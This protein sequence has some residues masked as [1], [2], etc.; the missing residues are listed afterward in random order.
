MKDK[1]WKLKNDWIFLKKYVSFLRFIFHLV[2]KISL[3]S[4]LSKILLFFDKKHLGI[5]SSVC[6]SVFKKS[7]WLIQISQV[8]FVVHLHSWYAQ[9][10]RL[11]LNVLKL[12]D[13]L[14]CRV[15]KMAR[16]LI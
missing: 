1:V 10:G 9:D 16:I 8:I 3:P 5:A 2:A 4:H 15:P 13:K 12:E 11:A 14:N 7:D 6:L